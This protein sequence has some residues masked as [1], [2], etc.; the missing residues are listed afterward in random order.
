M[1]DIHPTSINPRSGYDRQPG[2]IIELNGL[3]THR[4][5]SQPQLIR[6]LHGCAWI[7]VNAQDSVV[8]CDEIA[9]LAPGREHPIISSANRH[10]LVFEVQYA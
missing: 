2:E 5:E 1:T 10:R 6:V 4:L 8:P 7:T 9:L 3:E